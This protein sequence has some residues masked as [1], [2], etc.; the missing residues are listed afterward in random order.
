MSRVDD[1][2]GN[3]EL[4]TYTQ[5]AEAFSK[6]DLDRA[7]RDQALIHRA[8]LNDGNDYCRTTPSGLTRSAYDNLRAGRDDLDNR[9]WNSDT[10]FSGLNRAPQGP[11]MV[12]RGVETTHQ[13]KRRA[14]R[15]LLDDG[16]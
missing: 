7:L 13:K 8:Q 16:F 2:S 6:K 5:W 12:G 4:G 11:G 15:E 14:R 3:G 10:G 1:K 9:D